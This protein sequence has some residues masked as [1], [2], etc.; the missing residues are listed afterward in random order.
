MFQAAGAAGDALIAVAL[1]NSLFFAVPTA[2][3]R[4]RVALYLALTVAPFA[5]VAPLLSRVLDRHR[6]SMRI[7]MVIASLGRFVLAWL[8]ATRLDSLALFPVVFGILVLSRAAL[9]VRGAY[10]PSVVTGG[11]TLVQSNAALSKVSALAG[12]TAVLPGILLDR[13]IGPSTELYLTALVYLLGVAP[14]LRLPAV[15]GQREVGEQS[16][17]RQ[18]ARSIRIRQATVAVCGMRLLVG[19][20]VFHLAFALRREDHGTLQLG[21]LIASAATG[22]LFG[23][24]VAPWARRLMKEEGILGVSLIVAGIAALIAGKWF[25]VPSAAGL[26]F[27]F[28]VTSGAAKVAFDS[29]V[30]QTTPEAGRG[31]AFARFESVMQLSWVLGALV[32]LGLALSSGTGVITAGVLAVGLAA[33]YLISRRRARDL[34]LP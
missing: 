8:L 26:V 27:V 14:A 21:L 4:G 28:G 24:I 19:F 25:S 13:F 12:M 10:L 9:V 3:A 16:G 11:R 7:A 34:A 23:A 18:G 30:Q 31:W 1:A 33:L 29:I 17:A 6:G 20:L 15:K 5:I 32:P 22:T 2:E